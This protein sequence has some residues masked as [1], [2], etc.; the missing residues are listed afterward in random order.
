LVYHNYD[1]IMR[2]N[3]SQ[4]YALSVG[5]LADAV[6]MG[7]VHIYAPRKNIKFSYEQAK[8]IQKLLT[9]LGYYTGQIDG[10]LGSGSAQ[11]V[12]AYQKDYALP[13][14]GYATIELLNKMKGL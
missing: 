4:L 1:V 12:R 11:A 13:Q 6:V 8:E 10:I 14:D 9:K 5:L 2:W 7:Q 3:R